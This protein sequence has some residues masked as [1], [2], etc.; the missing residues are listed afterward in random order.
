MGVVQQ[1]A[2]FMAEPRPQLAELSRA[3]D[4]L[5]QEKVR[6]LCVELGVPPATLSNID[7]SHPRDALRC[8]T[9]YLEALLAY[10]ESLSWERIVEVLNSSRLRQHALAAT[11]RRTYCASYAAADGGLTL[12]PSPHR[13]RS[14]KT[15]EFTAREQCLW[16]IR[17]IVNQPPPLQYNLQLSAED[18]EVICASMEIRD[19]YGPREL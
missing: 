4:T 6:Y 3:L 2:R 9:E 12:P 1:D 13:S 19:L 18:I 7:A 14:S 16:R 15:G 11:I 10:D 5:S 8:I 17:Y